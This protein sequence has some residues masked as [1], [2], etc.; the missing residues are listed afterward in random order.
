MRK[1]D[2]EGHADERGGG[3]HRGMRDPIGKQGTQ[4]GLVREEGLR[5]DRGDPQEEVSHGQ[6]SGSNH[7]L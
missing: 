2:Y 5:E 3:R 7:D 6:N 4:W 1:P